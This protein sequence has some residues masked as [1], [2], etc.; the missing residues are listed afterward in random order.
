MHL[1]RVT[2]TGADDSI[3]PSDLL[4]LSEEFPFAE[5][6]ILVSKSSMGKSRFPSF[7][8]LLKFR[9]MT[10]TAKVHIDASMHLCG[11]WLR[12]VLVGETPSD[13]WTLLD[14]FQRA[15]L[16]FHAEPLECKPDGFRDAISA[17]SDE[18][19]REFIFQIDGNRGSNYLAE[20]A[21]ADLACVPLYDLSHGAGVLPEAWPPPM[22]GYAYQGY[23]GGL[24][25]D[26]LAEQI[27]LIGEAA[28]GTPFWIDM[29]T[30]VR[31]DSDRQFDLA[32]VRRCLEIAKPFVKVK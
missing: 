25:T 3:D 9:S 15:Q 2:I 7:D 18:G 4:A 28:R 27:P 11:R 19:Q 14:A 13:I 21:Q 17:F 22:K 23:A 30:K 10:R 6:G 29:E 12:D 16:N 24:G 5:W 26:N 32:K 8:W 20:A 31:S 1:D